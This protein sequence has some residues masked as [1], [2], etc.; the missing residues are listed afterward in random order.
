LTQA[1]LIEQVVKDV[2]LTDFSKGKDTPVNSILHA[3]KDGAER[4][5]SWSY[6]LVIRKLNYIANNTH[7]DLSMAIHQCIRY[8]H[9][10]KS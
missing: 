8:L 4:H 2:G 1:G 6:R 7:P 3:D 10:T 9:A 5:D